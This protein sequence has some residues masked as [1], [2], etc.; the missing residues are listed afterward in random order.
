M[1]LLSW[2]V[3]AQVIPPEQAEA[4]IDDLLQSHIAAN[5]P[6]EADFDRFLRRDLV[7]YFTE[8]GQPPASV[9]YE[10]L[11]NEPSQVGIGF[12]KYYV[13]VSVTRS[14]KQV[15]RGAGRLAAIQRE[16]F[17]VTHFVSE[18]D[19]QRDPGQLGRL[20]PAPVIARINEKIRDG[21]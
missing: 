12:P 21:K 1:A 2:R 10:L 19:I 16:R 3:P 13:W 11:S 5:V 17:E 15:I 4:V 20:F 18:V 8:S 14:G 6:A 7:S 9:Q